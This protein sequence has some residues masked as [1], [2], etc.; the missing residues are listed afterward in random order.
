[1]A[2][3]FPPQQMVSLLAVA[4]PRMVYQVPPQQMVAPLPIAQ[5]GTA[6]QV[7]PQQ[8]VAPLPTA[9]P[10][11][12][13]QYPPQQV[14]AP[15]P[16]A[17]PGT[18]CELPP[19]DVVVPLPTAEH[20][21]AYQLPPQDIMAPLH[22]IAQHSVWNN[23]SSSG[24]Y[25]TDTSE[26]NE[27]R[28]KLGLVQFG[29]FYKNE[30]LQTTTDK[31]EILSSLGKGGFGQVL[32]GWNYLTG[33]YVA[34]KVLEGVADKVPREIEYL[35]TIKQAN[36]SRSHIV[37]FHCAF[38]CKKQYCIVQESLD[39][40]LHVFMQ[41]RNYPLRIKE[42]RPIIK[43][44]FLALDKLQALK[45]VHTDI[46]PE[47]I[48]FVSA[49]YA[50]Y[51]IKIVDFGNAITEKECDKHKTVQPVYYRAPEVILGT[52]YGNAIDIWSVGCIAAEL[53]LGAVLYKGGTP[54]DQIRLICETQGY[55]D[56]RMLNEGLYTKE[57]FKNCGHLYWKLRSPEEYQSRSNV[58]SK[59]DCRNRY[60]SLD[61]FRYVDRFQYV[62]QTEFADK[63]SFIELLKQM[64]SISDVLRIR[65]R[66]A[67][68]HRFITME[69]F[70]GNYNICS[71]ARECCEIMKVAN[72]DYQT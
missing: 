35:K 3:D 29:K 19:Q 43:Q 12:V 44:L 9:P 23:D 16:T 4:P 36:G 14:A 27:S 48:M 52:P 41:R 65:A 66:T 62:P 25:S 7:P 67:L 47:N 57:Y 31:Y 56:V 32:L 59:K 63:C 33:R 26:R 68:Y 21:M 60:N 5:P 53:Y 45:I 17:Q 70:V 37:D 69:G 20:S 40:S 39:Q 15:L 6:Y 28:K 64:L 54:Y 49:T 2:Y 46:K 24:V 50:P 34:I 61:S 1:M 8:T 18:A 55:P 22:S 13:Y 42:I 51:R 38:I 11:M 30:V 71:Y 58:E 72:T 10:D